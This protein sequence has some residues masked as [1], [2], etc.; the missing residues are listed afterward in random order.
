LAKADAVIVVLDGCVSL[1]AEDRAV[2]QTVGEKKTV[3]VV[4]KSDLPTILS[5]DELE[6][7]ND[8]RIAVASAK[9]GAGI[10][11]IKE[12]LRELILGCAV[13]P[14]VTVTNIRHKS[15]LIRSG[16][17]LDR[18][19]NTLSRNLPPELVAVDLNEAR[20]ALE[21]II[22]VVSSDDILERIFSNFCIGK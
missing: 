21:E 1:G 14:A 8:A 15:E 6:L 10:S 13:E 19:A 5:L 22:G 2:L 9:S 12:A 7:N 20:D 4:N 16:N 3:V 17:A 18:A 11:F